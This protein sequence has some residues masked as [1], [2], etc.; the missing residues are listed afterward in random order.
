MGA[1]ISTSI[2]NVDADEVR[3]SKLETDGVGPFAVVRL[4]PDVTI[5]VLRHEAAT[6]AAIEAACREAREW[7]EAQ[8]APSAEP[9][10]HL[11]DF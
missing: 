1:V 11:E 4:S 5:T 2:H 7:L 3:V 9:E 6:L 8:P 10:P